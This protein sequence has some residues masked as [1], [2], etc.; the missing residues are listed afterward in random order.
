MLRDVCPS[1]RWDAEKRWKK[2]APSWQ[3]EDLDRVLIDSFETAVPRP[4]TEPQQRRCYSGKKKRPTLKTQVVTDAAGELLEIDAGHRGPASDK[5]LYEQ[6]GVGVR[7]GT[8]VKQGDLGY[9]GCAE[10]EVPYKKPKGG[11]LTPEQRA[12]NQEQAKVRVHVE[13]AIRRLK[14]FKI[15]RQDYRLATGLFPCVASVVAG[16]VHVNRFVG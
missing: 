16:L 1:P 11:E 12:A 4:S 8:A 2:S 7:Y 10:M 14:G 13:H 15:V 9:Q 3:P 5:R 6:S